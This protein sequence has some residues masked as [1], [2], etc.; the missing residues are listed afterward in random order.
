MF[1]Y[2][3]SRFKLLSGLTHADGEQPA[4]EDDH[5]DNEQPEVDPDDDG[6]ATI[7][8]Q[9]E[10]F[11]LFPIAGPDE[12]EEFPAGAS[13][14]AVDVIAVHGLGGDAYRTW[15]HANGHLWLRD[16]FDEIPGA[17]VYTYGYDSG[18]A[19]SRGTGTLRDFARQLLNFVRLIRRTDEVRNRFLH[20]ARIFS[21]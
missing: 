5:L 14:Y 17:R 3:A 9:N 8:S 1:Q 11:G 18:Y 4:R 13:V 21:A 15:E 16:I 10:Q 2:F 20:R 7:E 19:F 12:D 6:T